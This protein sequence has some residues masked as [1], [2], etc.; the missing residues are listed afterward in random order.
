MRELDQQIDRVLLTALTMT[1]VACAWVS[2]SYRWASS[3]YA[4][5]LRLNMPFARLEPYDT[6]TKVTR[7]RAQFDEELAVT[8]VVFDVAHRQISQLAV[9]TSMILRNTDG[10][11]PMC[12]HFGLGLGAMF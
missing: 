1:S 2:S 6:M 10:P 9:K 4:S 3:T 8:D 7:A 11:S 12:V 5:A